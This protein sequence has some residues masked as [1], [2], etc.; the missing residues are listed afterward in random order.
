VKKLLPERKREKPQIVLTN[1]IDVILLLVFFFMITSSF[2]K[3]TLK[4]PINLPKASSG[5]IIDADTLRVQMDREGA[6]S[7]DGTTLTAEELTARVGAFL[8]ENREKP[9]VLEADQSADYGKVI[10]VLDIMRIAG[11]VNL[12][13]SSKPKNGN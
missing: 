8:G 10:Q 12:G 6:I 4:L 1:L 13:L 9:I 5:A 11:G 3:E 7:A 2:A